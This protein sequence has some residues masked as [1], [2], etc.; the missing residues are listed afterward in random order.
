MEFARS[1]PLQLLVT[2]GAV[3]AFFPLLAWVSMFALLLRR[4]LGQRHREES[5]LTL[6]GIGALLVVGLDGLAEFNLA[7]ESVPATLACVLG[8]ALAAGDGSRRRRPG[9]LGPL[10]TPRLRPIQSPDILGG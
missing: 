5:A 10:E 1:L 6:V 2:G 3:G 9:L 4:F 8:L 7:A